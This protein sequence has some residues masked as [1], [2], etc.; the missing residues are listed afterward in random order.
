MLNCDRASFFVYNPATEDLVTILPDSTDQISI[1]AD[2]TSIAGEAFINASVINLRSAYDHPN[3]NREIDRRTGYRTRSMLALPI[4]L[5][6]QERPLGVVQCINK[7]G[8]VTIES[9]GRNT[10]PEFST[11]DEQTLHAFVSQ[12][13]PAI[14]KVRLKR[15]KARRSDQL[16]TSWVENIMTLS[17]LH[18]FDVVR[19]M[20]ERMREMVHADRASLFIL[21]KKKKELWSK[22]AHDMKEIR[23]K[24]NQGIVGAVATSGKILNIEDAYKDNRFNRRIDAATGYRTRQIL[25][26]PIKDNNA[27]VVGVV[28]CIN[29]TTSTLSVFTREDEHLVEELCWQTSA[30]L[31]HKMKELI[32]ESNAT[33]KLK[34]DVDVMTATA[35]G[36]A[37]LLQLVQSSRSSI[38][39]HASSALG[40]VCQTE[41]N[42]ERLMKLGGVPVLLDL[43]YPHPWRSRETLRG[44]SLSLANVTISPAVREEV[45]NSGGAWKSLL[46]L[47]NSSDSEVWFDALRVL[48]NLALHPMLQPQMVSAGVLTAVLKY[49]TH[50]DADL[51][52]QAARL[53]GNLSEQVATNE[54]A[55]R[56]LTQPKII[57]ALG[58][59]CLSATAANDGLG[60]PGCFDFAHAYT[61]LTL[62]PAYAAWLFTPKG[63]EVLKGLLGYAGPSVEDVRVQLVAMISCCL[64]ERL[65]QR[66]FLELISSVDSSDESFRKLPT[67]QQ[68]LLL[69]KEKEALSTGAVVRDI[70]N[71]LLHERQSNPQVLMHYA[72]ALETLTMEPSNHTPMLQKNYVQQLVGVANESIDTGPAQATATALRGLYTILDVESTP[73]IHRL[74]LR[75]PINIAPTLLRAGLSE[76]EPTMVEVCRIV[77][78]MGRHAQTG[79]KLAHQTHQTAEAQYDLFSVLQMILSSGSPD[80]QLEACRALLPYGAMHKVE[81]CKARLVGPLIK[82]SQS[83]RADLAEASKAVLAAL[84]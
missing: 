21:D 78:V 33:T 72:C 8:A 73:E 49:L 48:A 57:E 79:A 67:R 14:D 7:K 23:V 53:L 36:V 37:Q 84:A 19:A 58:R 55:M 82:L 47:L 80:V 77:R 31:V 60:T 38:Q 17:T 52:A 63:V 34:G 46:S 59:A 13:A 83:A 50:E 12:I 4:L 81:I 20:L 76:D 64:R 26:V 30:L 15:R 9:D 27:E 70:T 71:Q 43:A 41:A 32:E 18:P 45:A 61:K 62:V 16:G 25:C 1:P 68:R 66:T 2:S 5:E 3:F 44:V 51:Q 56:E 40:W 35:D 29:K 42:R 39:L 28:Q 74:L 11:E 22:I 6:G 54:K 65:N 69:I 10:L 75:A 24:S